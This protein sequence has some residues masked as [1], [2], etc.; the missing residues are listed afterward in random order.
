MLLGYVILQVGIHLGVTRIDF[1]GQAENQTLLFN[2]REIEELDKS[3]ELRKT[4]CLLFEQAVHLPFHSTGRQ[5]IALRGDGIFGVAC[6]FTEDREYF[7]FVKDKPLKL[8][9]LL[10]LRV[11]S[12][13]PNF[14]QQILI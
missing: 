6:F 12:S 4:A 7:V 9:Q 13:S 1:R 10:L 14:A 3:V 5:E 2:P 11:L 8:I